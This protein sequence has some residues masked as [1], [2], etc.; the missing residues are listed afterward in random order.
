MTFDL[1][2]HIQPRQ[3]DQYSW[4]YETMTRLGAPTPINDNNRPIS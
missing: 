3:G 4:L 1:T 2:R